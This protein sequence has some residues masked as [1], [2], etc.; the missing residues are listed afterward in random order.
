MDLFTSALQAR[1]PLI[2]AQ[3]TDVV[4][5]SQV[6]QKISGKKPE[7]F[8]PKKGPAEDTIYLAIATPSHKYMIGFE[9]EA[10]HALAKAGST[11]VM[12][13]L[14]SPEAVYFN[15]GE[16]PIIQSI[17]DKM[18]TTVVADEEQAAA[19]RLK[20]GNVTAKEAG[21]ILR[22]TMK[23][24]GVLTPGAVENTRR[25]AFQGHRGVTQVSTE[26]VEYQAPEWLDALITR[27]RPFFL[28]AKAD[29]RLR[30]R[31]LLF[32]GIPG[33]GKTAAAKYIAS[34][35]GVPLFRV[36]L[37]NTK[38][39]YVGESEN[40]LALILSQLDRQEPCVALFD[41]VEKMLASAGK[42]AGFDTSGT[43]QS[44]LS[45]LLWWMA[46]R[47]TRV[48]AILTTNDRKVIPPELYREGRVDGVHVFEGLT[49]KEAPEFAQLVLKQFTAAAHPPKQMV[50]ET[51]SELFED[52]VRIPHATVE[53][54]IKRL[55][56]QTITA[57]LALS[58]FKTTT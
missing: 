5:L 7:T 58:K 34:E 21:E 54:R 15:A 43:T 29:P 20:L 10:Y 31:G 51:I 3:T 47:T 37:G 38:N 46:E 42:G 52:D 28:N 6:I 25:A 26:G 9:R 39:K 24:E 18:I 35:F 48:L 53:V 40:Q 14:R 44:M 13:N 50:A 30:I 57:N 1:L 27:E 41:E 45:Q 4:Y 16:V 33:T 8:D 2:A 17:I 55:I 22:L 49:E 19:I 12:A 23:R 32:D 56:K 11:L 36:D